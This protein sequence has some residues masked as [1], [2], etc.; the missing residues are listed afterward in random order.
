MSVRTC[1]NLT[2]KADEAVRVGDVDFILDNLRQ[3]KVKIIA[4]R[5]VKIIRVKKKDLFKD[6]A[7]AELEIK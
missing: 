4:P 5:D 3:I 7:K 2:I 6:L 1:L